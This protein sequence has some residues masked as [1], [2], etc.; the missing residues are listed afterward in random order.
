MRAVK[1]INLGQLAV[2]HF[3]EQR[4]LPLFG[5]SL[6][7][8]QVDHHGL[9]LQWLRVMHGNV[10][11]RFNHHLFALAGGLLAQRQVLRYLAFLAAR[12]NAGIQPSANSFGDVGPRETKRQ[13]RA[14][15]AQRNRDQARAGKTQPFDACRTH[16]IAQRT[17]GMPWQKILDTVQA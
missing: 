17:A 7:L 4:L 16:Q 12:L 3:A 10:F 5:H 9:D 14:H 8:G 11:A 13:C 2:R 15:Q 1:Q 6:A